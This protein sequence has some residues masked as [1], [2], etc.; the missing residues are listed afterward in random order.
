MRCVQ[1]M[2]VTTQNKDYEDYNNYAH[3]DVFRSLLSF[4]LCFM[5]FLWI[6][7][8][9]LSLVSDAPTSSKMVSFVSCISPRIR[10]TKCKVLSFWVL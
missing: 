2:S 7:V 9:T 1:G 5:L 8:F 10:N 4:M 6:L 3:A